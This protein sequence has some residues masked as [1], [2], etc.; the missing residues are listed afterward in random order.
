MT[1]FD[2]KSPDDSELINALR[3]LEYSDSRDNDT[4]Y[5]RMDREKKYYGAM[6]EINL[7]GKNND[8]IKITFDANY[9][10]VNR[11]GEYV[12]PQSQHNSEFIATINKG[13]T[14]VA[15]CNLFHDM[16]NRPNSAE[17]IP[18]KQMHVLKYTGITEKNN[19]SYY[20]FVH[21]AGYTP[22]HIECKFPEIVQYSLDIDF[23]ISDTNFYADV[24]DFNWT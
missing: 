22:N 1:S 13:D 3:T 17:D 14:F 8:S 4:H 9:F 20:G 10:Q 16:P 21:E 24:W 12:K 11:D 18:A 6:R 19:T 15:K 7:V 23:D 5:E 2:D